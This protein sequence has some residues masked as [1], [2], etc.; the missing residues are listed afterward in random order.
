MMLPNE[1]SVNPQKWVDKHADY[2]YAYAITRINDE[3]VVR[4]LVQETFLAALEALPEF[5]GK[6][7]ERTWLTAILKYKIID[8]YRKKSRQGIKVPLGINEERVE[9]FD[10]DLNNWKKEH[11]PA[12][13]GVEDQDPL[14]NKELNNVLQDC[15]KKLPPLWLTIFTMKHMD[16]SSKDV[17]CD[18]LKLSE[19]NFWVIIHRAKV[20]LRSCLQKRWF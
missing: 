19:S 12:P 17:I 20:S 14:H 15:M 13:F 7:T 6:S 18:E 11:W 9:Y 10:P 1:L 2:L 8:T 4:D 5:E 16:D 3:E